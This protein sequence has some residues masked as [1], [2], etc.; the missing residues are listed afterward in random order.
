[1]SFT[2]APKSNTFKLLTNM[3]GEPLSPFG[4]YDVEKVVEPVEL[5]KHTIS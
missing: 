4:A 3:A 2:P 1:M 5:S